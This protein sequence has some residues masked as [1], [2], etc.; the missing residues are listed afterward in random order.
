MGSQKVVK[1]LVA[2]VVK[3]YPSGFILLA[4]LKDTGVDMGYVKYSIGG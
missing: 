4:R 1:S 2:G 3:L